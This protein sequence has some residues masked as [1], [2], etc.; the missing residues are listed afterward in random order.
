MSEDYAPVYLLYPVTVSYDD[1]DDAD[2]DDADE[3][4]ECT[5]DLENPEICESCT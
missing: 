1:W 4:F 3:V 2:W 5:L